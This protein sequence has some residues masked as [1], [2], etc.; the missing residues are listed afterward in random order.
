MK[1]TVLYELKKKYW[2]RERD[3]GANRVLK[4][5]G[6]TFTL[7]AYDIENLGAMSVIEMSAMFGL[8]QMESYILTADKK[9]L[10]LYNGDFIKAAGKCTLLEEFYDTM[11]TPLDEE[12][13]NRYREVKARYASL[14]PYKTEPRWYDPL[15]FY[16]RSDRQEL[17]EN[18]GRHHSGLSGSVSGQCG[19]GTGLRPGDQ[20]G[21][22]EGLCRRPVRE[23][24]TG[25]KSVQKAFRGRE[26]PR[27]LRRDRL[28]LPV[29]GEN[30]SSPVLKSCQ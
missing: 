10:P 25:G 17:K 29:K 13:V 9:D 30:L 4:K 3:L 23:W 6:M 12:S 26:I 16:A 21:E 15:R 20:E 24:R 8:M 2:V 5:N 1:K 18:Q 22:D 28:L 14:P 11:I 7:S 27:N 19:N